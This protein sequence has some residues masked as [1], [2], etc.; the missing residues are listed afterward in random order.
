LTALQ[1]QEAEKQFEEH[2]KANELMLYK[3]CSMYAYTMADKEDLFQEIV[4]RKK[5]RGRSMMEIQVV[6]LMIEIIIFI[7][8]RYL[9]LEIKL[10]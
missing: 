1:T 9:V 6:L 4:I 5:N 3:L 7:C 8:K 10:E 2:I